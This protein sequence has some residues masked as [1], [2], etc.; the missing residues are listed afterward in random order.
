VGP[1]L[2]LRVPSKWS[3]EREPAE[4]PRDKFNA[5]GGWLPPLTSLAASPTLPAWKPFA[6]H[7]PSHLGW[8]LDQF[9]VWPP[10]ST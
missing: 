1:Q 6:D 2:S 8:R 9:R 7:A 4:S 3:N 5:I 10:L